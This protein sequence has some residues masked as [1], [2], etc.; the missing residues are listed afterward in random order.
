VYD[1]FPVGSR[2]PFTLVAHCGV[3]FATFDGMTW[4]TRRRDDGQGNP[5]PGWPQ[6]IP[7]TLSR[8]TPGRI[9]FVSDEIPERIV[10]HAAP[11]RTWACY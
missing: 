9:V 11:G 5:P 10:F 3:E 8:P 1:A 4:R 6:Q 7:G 2:V